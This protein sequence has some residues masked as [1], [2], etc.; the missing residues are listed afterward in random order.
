MKSL[1]IYKVIKNIFFPPAQT[2]M[3]LFENINDLYKSRC[4]S[5]SLLQRQQL[6]IYLVA[7]LQVR[8]RQI[9]NKKYQPSVQQ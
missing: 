1:G 3:S 4:V 6:D 7:F 2:A 8:V 5:Q 9:F